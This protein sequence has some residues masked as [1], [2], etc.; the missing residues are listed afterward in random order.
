MFCPCVNC[1]NGRR[2]DIELIR[3]HVLCDGFLKSYTIWTWH[4]EVLEQY[5]SVSA[6]K[7]E[8]S[9]LY[10][11]ACMEDMIRDIGEYSFHHAHVYGSLK[12][13]SETELYPGCSSF[14][15]LQYL[16]SRQEMGGLKKVLPNCSNRFIKFF[17]K[18]IDCQPVTMRPRRYCVQWV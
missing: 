14:T 7:C 3:E 18:V 10:S 9:N 5:S 2:Q 12:D 6:I 8:Y 4:A 17:Q 11:E 16:I 15:R 1:L 13:D